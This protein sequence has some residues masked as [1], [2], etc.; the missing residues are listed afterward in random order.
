L[1]TAAIG[2][3]GAINAALLAAVWLAL[4][5]PAAVQHKNIVALAQKTQTRRVAERPEGS[6]RDSLKAGKLK[7]RRQPSENSRAATIEAGKCWP[8]GA[9]AGLRM[10]GVFFGRI[11]IRR[12]FFFFFC[13]VLECDMRGICR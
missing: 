10:P 2:K 5:D 1:G 6:W 7:A 11:R 4:N 9:A 3:P 13:V 12:R 8:C